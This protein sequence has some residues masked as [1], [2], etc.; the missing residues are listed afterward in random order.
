M[1]TK[2]LLFLAA[3][4]LLAA[5]NVG[6]LASADAPSFKSVVLKYKNNG[7]V[8]VTATAEGLTAAPGGDVTAIVTALDSEACVIGQIEIQLMPDGGKVKFDAEFTDLPE[9]P[10]ALVNVQ[11]F[12]TGVSILGVF[13]VTAD[14]GTT[15]KLK[16]PVFIPP[17]FSCDII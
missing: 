4:G 12:E 10:S 17:V 5:L 7:N 1:K 3:V 16:N 14:K 2:L 9:E 15:T 6:G 11:V 13:H 8:S